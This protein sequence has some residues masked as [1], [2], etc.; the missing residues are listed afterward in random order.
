MTITLPI[1]FSTAF[2]IANN[3]ILYTSV[4][5]DRNSSLTSYEASKLV[6]RFDDWTAGA[7]FIAIGK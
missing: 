3:D 6:I 2:S 5:G 7:F 1:S 4:G